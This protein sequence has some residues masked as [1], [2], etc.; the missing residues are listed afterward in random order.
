MNIQGKKVA[1]LV[2]NYFEQAEFEEPLN[3]LKKAGAD[4]TVITASN[5][6]SLQGLNHVEM[7]DKFKADI[8]LTD[9]NCDDYD[10]LVLPGGAINADSLRM[11][12]K[13]H[14]WVTDFMDDNKPIAAICHAPWLLA[15]ADIIEGHRL[16][17]FFT[18]Q[19]DLKNAG[20]EWVDIAVVVDNNL[21]T[22]RTPDDLKQFDDAII[23]M[24]SQQ[25]ASIN[26]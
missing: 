13:A 15:S 11:V 18:I 22:S 19:D 2:H 20:A 23:C 12:D 21:I 3:T 8:K 9:A 26:G 10:A 25:T 5:D 1:M 16:T 4:V 24:L 14:E 17:S 7:G 6:L